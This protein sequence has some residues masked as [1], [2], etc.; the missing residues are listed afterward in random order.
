MNNSIKLSL[1]AAVAVF[2]LGTTAQA[3]DLINNNTYGVIRGDVNQEARD[4]DAEGVTANIGG[5]EYD[6]SV[7]RG[8]VSNNTTYGRIDSLNQYADFNAKASVKVGAISGGAAV[9]DNNTTAYAEDVFQEALYGGVAE[10]DLGSLST[11]SNS[12][13]ENNTAA[14]TVEGSISQITRNST[15]KLNVGSIKSK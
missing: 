4:S 12:L 6:N 11:D 10:I 14:G 1:L 15:V 7:F 5:I 2:S 9:V 13:I 3:N 8:E